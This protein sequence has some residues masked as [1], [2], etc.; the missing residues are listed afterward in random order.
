MQCHQLFVGERL[1]A[2]NICTYHCLHVPVAIM[3]AKA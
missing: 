2:L 3:L 1:E